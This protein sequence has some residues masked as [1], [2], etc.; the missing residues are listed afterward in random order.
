VPPG[1]AGLGLGVEDDEVQAEPAQM[2]PGGEPGLATT[3]HHDLRAVSAHEVR[4]VLAVDG[5]RC[6]WAR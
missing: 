4:M 2:E 3:D 5:Q 6:A 1:A